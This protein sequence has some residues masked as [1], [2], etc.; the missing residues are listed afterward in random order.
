MLEECH[1]ESMLELTE[2][3]QRALQ[4]VCLRTEVKQEMYGAAHHFNWKKVGLSRAYYNERRV[5]EASM[6]TDRS[7]AALRLSL[8]HI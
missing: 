6:P 7:R 1:G 8:I 5:C 4:V 2:V 3:E